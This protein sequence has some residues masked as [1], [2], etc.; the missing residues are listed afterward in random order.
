MRH[1]V[2]IFNGR[3][4]EQLESQINEW[5]ENQRDVAILNIQYAISQSSSIYYDYSALIHYMEVQ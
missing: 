4:S 2:K 5:F 1:Q 3:N